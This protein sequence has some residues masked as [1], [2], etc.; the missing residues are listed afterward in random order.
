MSDSGATGSSFSMNLA[1]QRKP[2]HIDNHFFND[3]DKRLRNVS[4]AEL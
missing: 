1:L 3:R 4:S 2:R